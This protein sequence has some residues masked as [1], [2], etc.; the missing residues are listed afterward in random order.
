MRGKTKARDLSIISHIKSLNNDDSLIE[1]SSKMSMISSKAEHFICI[2]LVGCSNFVICIK[3]GNNPLNISFISTKKNTGG[4]NKG[5]NI[6]I[7]QCKGDFICIADH[8]DIWFS[9]KIIQTV[10][11]YIYVYIYLSFFS[12]EAM[13]TKRE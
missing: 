1:N 10:V 5:R 7:S 6:A 12:D 4:P 8:D 3:L 13:C 2:N 11:Q 9:N